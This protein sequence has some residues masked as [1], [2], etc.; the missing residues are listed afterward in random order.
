MAIIIIIF[1]FVPTRAINFD[2]KVFSLDLTILMEIR[3]DMMKTISI[4]LAAMICL[5]ILASAV[6]DSVITGPYNISFDLGLP[7]DVYTKTAED[8]KETESL[9]GE[10]QTKYSIKIENKSDSLQLISIS[11]TEYA[12]E[13]TG[14]SATSAEMEKVL[15]KMFPSS[16]N[17]ASRTIDEKHGVIAEY[18][19]SGITLYTAVYWPNARLFA[20][21]VSTYPW[22]EGT[23][24]LLK[25]IHIEK[26]NSSSLV[27][28]I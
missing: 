14:A 15:K 17:T 12:Q 8:P 27:G 22:D 13:Q 18:S 6:P 21:L 24:S 26:I 1:L 23:L 4:V 7:K 19:S 3:R 10:S 5:P 16:A 20:L 11:M 2:P 28:Q 9:G 25:T